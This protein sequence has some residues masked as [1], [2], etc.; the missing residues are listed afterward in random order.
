[1][2]IN[3]KIDIETVPVELRGRID[4][5]ITGIAKLLANDVINGKKDLNEMLRDI[6]NSEIP[7]AAKR[8]IVFRMGLEI[9]GIYKFDE[10]TLRVKKEE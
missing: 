5:T 2:E 6:E 8:W 10:T 1:M 4:A 7:D 3:K 9:P